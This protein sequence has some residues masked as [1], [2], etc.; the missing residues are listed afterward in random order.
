MIRRFSIVTFALLIIAA[1]PHPEAGNAA[2]P[3]EP[4]AAAW[5]MSIAVPSAGQ[6]LLAGQST[7]SSGQQ[8]NASA[9]AFSAGGQGTGAVFSDVQHPD[10]VKSVKDFTDPAFP[11][12]IPPIP[13]ATLNNGVC[14][15]GGNL[16]LRG[17]FAEAHTTP[18]ASNSQAGIAAGTGNGFA[19]ASKNF[20]FQQQSQVLNMIQQINDTVL[21]PV[22]TLI[23]QIAPTLHNNNINLPHLSGPPPTGLIDI[24][25]LGA[26][27]SSSQTSSSPGFVSATSSSAIN[28]VKLLAGFIELHG[29]KASADSESNSGTDSRSGSASIGTLTIAGLT[30]VADDTGFHLAGNDILLK[31]AVQPAIDM[32][33]AGLKQAGMTIQVQQVEALGDLRSATAFDLSMAT[34]N[35]LLHITLGHADAAAQSVAAPV[36]IPPVIPPLPGGG[37]PPVIPPPVAPS[38]VPGTT[39]PGTVV[40]PAGAVPSNGFFYR[41][42]GIDVA[43]ALHTVYLI[44]LVGGLIGSLLYPMFLKR[45]PHIRRRPLLV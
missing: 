35:G 11:L 4:R 14:D 19:F 18:S 22:N 12:C 10:A 20:S 5:A 21:G 8:P 6:V 41:R 32:L 43:R 26:S 27:S 9:T 44:F 3:A 17:G 42:P 29:V 7:A 40:P 25:D 33:M 31:Q 37:V 28:D 24:A 2:T 38:L 39:V 16:A 45:A 13:Q 15:P 36:V 23:D 34:P 30:M 1:L